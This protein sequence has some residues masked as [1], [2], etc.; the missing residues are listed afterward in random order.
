MNLIP[1]VLGSLKDIQNL[2]DIL[3]NILLHVDILGTEQM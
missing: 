1:D 2:L 3:L